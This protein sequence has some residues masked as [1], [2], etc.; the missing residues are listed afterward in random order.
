MTRRWTT[1]FAAAVLVVAT[2]GVGTA[3]P[4]SIEEL[5]ARAEQGDGLLQFSLG[6]RYGEGDGVPQDGM[7]AVRWYRLAAE[8]GNVAAMY[9]LAITYHYARDVPQDDMQ[10]YMWFNL[11]AS[12]MIGEDRDKAVIGR[13]IIARETMN[14][15]LTPDQRAEAQR[16][17]LEWDEAHPVSIDGLADVLR[18]AFFANRELRAKAEQG[19]AAAQHDLGV[20]YVNG[21]GVPQV[22]AEA[23]RWFRLA[24]EQGL[25]RA[26]NKLG[27]S[28]AESEGVP[29]D[30]AKAVR[31]YRLAA[32][33]G[34]SNAQ[35]NLGFMYNNGRGVPED[36]LEAVRWWR[37]AADQGEV[38]AQVYLGWMYEYGDGVPQDDV[39]AHMW[40]NI[41]A[42]RSTGTQHANAVENRDRV[43]N[44]LTPDQRAEAQ[45]LA[46]EWDEAH[47]RD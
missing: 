3:Q 5:R 46:R 36:D 21:E 43:T 42:S 1:F 7:E 10:A 15:R 22:S 27:L 8:Q 6:Y 31:W 38:D 37:L 41:A 28:Y 12:R 34:L 19:D 45:R 44:L 40:F 25:A 32:E 18:P 16:L 11:A 17:A 14:S 30:D 35:Y 39:Q 4:E 29:Q 23:V 26:Q 33:Q 24:A 9:N 47:P 20:L 13:D 2:A